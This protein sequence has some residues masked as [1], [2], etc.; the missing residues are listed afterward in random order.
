MYV[1]RAAS[2]HKDPFDRIL[3]AQAMADN[4]TLVTKDEILA[5]YPANVLW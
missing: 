5:Q 4:L 2:I 3:L 1:G